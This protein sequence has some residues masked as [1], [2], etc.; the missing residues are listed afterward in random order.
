MTIALQHIFVPTAERIVYDKQ[1]LFSLKIQRKFLNSIARTLN[2][3]HQESALSEGN[4]CFAN[5]PGLRSEYKTVFTSV[6][7][8]HYVYAMLTQ[9]EI[10]INIDEVPLPTDISSFWNAVEKG[11]NQTKISKT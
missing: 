11:E 9:E 1:E 2:L 5:N 10:N 4:L 7:I 3:T 8:A 6:D